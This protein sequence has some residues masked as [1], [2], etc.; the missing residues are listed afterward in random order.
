MPNKKK[1]EIF[2][3]SITESDV[4]KQKLADLEKRVR[5]LEE[6]LPLDKKLRKK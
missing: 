1:L 6:R 3:S 5:N 4:I 2:P